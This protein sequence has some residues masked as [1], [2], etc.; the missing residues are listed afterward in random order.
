M[1]ASHEKFHDLWMD[2]LQQQL[3]ALGRD[4]CGAHAW[5]QEWVRSRGLGACAVAVRLLGRLWLTC[6]CAMWVHCSSSATRACRCVPD[7]DDVPIESRCT[8]VE[9]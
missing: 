9:D 4:C 5:T 3:K 6:M 1:D 8:A 2:T 7:Q